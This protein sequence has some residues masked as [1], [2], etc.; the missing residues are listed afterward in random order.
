MESIVIP[1]TV[2]DLV[3]HLLECRS[4]FVTFK[5]N[6]KCVENIFKFHNRAIALFIGVY[7]MSI[8]SSVVHY[9]ST[10]RKLVC[11]EFVVFQNFFIMISTFNFIP[12]K[13]IAAHFYMHI[14]HQMKI[15]NGLLKRITVGFEESRDTQKEILERLIVCIKIEQ[16][17][18]RYVCVSLNLNFLFLIKLH[19]IV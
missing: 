8:T 2:Q 16:N 9:Y 17:I 19:Y 4:T 15:L 7:I 13:I 11:H 18:R 6:Y 3:H 12:A 5:V 14:E 10:Q 1:F